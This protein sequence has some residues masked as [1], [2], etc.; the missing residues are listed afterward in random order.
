MSQ[1]NPTALDIAL[2]FLVYSPVLLK[3][4]IIHERKKRN[5][6]GNVILIIIQFSLLP[7]LII[8]GLRSN[9]SQAH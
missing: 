8:I 5:H 1:R 7:P 9:I 6:F 3:S 4:L 2:Q